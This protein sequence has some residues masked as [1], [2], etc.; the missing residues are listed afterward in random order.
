SP[1]GTRLLG[2][3]SEPPAP[4]HRWANGWSGNLCCENRWRNHPTLRLPEL[5][6]PVVCRKWFGTLK[7]SRFQKDPTH[8]YIRWRLR[9]CCE[10]RSWQNRISP[11]PVL[12]LLT[13]CSRAEDTWRPRPLRPRQCSVAHPV[14]SRSEEHTSELQSPYDL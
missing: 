12:R 3:N 10:R 7:P 14:Q 8:R 11:R 1:P 4:A 9:T 6:L 5:L 2:K 13:P